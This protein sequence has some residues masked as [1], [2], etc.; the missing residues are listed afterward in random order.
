MSFAFV[1]LRETGNLYPGGARFQKAWCKHEKK[2]GR[3]RKLMAYFRICSNFPSFLC[4]AM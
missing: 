4:Q 3:I 1:K 2:F